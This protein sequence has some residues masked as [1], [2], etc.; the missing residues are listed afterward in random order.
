MILDCSLLLY[1]FTYTSTSSNL[2]N[3]RGPDPCQ[4]Q[5]SQPLSLLLLIPL[6]IMSKRIAT[7]QISDRNPVD[8]SDSEEEEYYNSSASERESTRADEEELRRRK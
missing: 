2:R 8:P 6:S 3:H 4:T 7:F 5:K 1:N